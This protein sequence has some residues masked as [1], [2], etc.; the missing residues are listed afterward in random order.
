[1]SKVSRRSGVSIIRP[2]I[3]R[4]RCSVFK[5]F[6]RLWLDR[7]GYAEERHLRS[8]L[9]AHSKVTLLL[10]PVIISGWMLSILSVNI[11]RCVGFLEELACYTLVSK[12]KRSYGVER[13]IAQTCT[14]KLNQA[15]TVCMRNKASK[16]SFTPSVKAKDYPKISRL[17]ACC[18]CHEALNCGGCIAS[19]LLAATYPPL[20]PTTANK[21]SNLGNPKSIFLPPIPDEC[22]GSRTVCPTSPTGGRGHPSSFVSTRC[23]AG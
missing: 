8:F 6:W 19:H 23:P 21:N 3:I 1:M 14:S 9:L 12:A 22:I 7:L 10:L 16:H 13:E 5:E 15:M 4:A 18:V 11:G 20:S 17:S 2:F